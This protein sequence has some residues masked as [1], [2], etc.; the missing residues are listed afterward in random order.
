M[1]TKEMMMNSRSWMNPLKGSAGL[2]LVVFVLLSA[3]SKKSDDV[4]PAA[5]GVQ[6]KADAHF[7]NIIADDLGKTLYFFSTDNAGSN[8]C[9]GGCIANWPI[10]Y[11]SNPT[12]GSGLSQD[13]F[14]EITTAD[15]RKQT[16]YKGWPLYYFIDDKK[17]GDIFG[18]K[19]GN[20]WYV[21][22][23]DYEVM[24]SVNPANNKKYI[25]APKGK[26]LYI[27]DNDAN[28]TSSCTG[29]CT[30]NWP[31]FTINTG[32]VPSL[33]TAT[34]FSIVNG[35]Q[36]ATYKGKPLY[37][38]GQDAVRGDLRGDGAANGLWHMIDET[39]F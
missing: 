30:T 6:V 23:P 39:R 29:A 15:G 22:K 10:F 7:G 33:L 31:A 32:N 2:T 19:S 36:Q 26:T 12:L 18:D 9:T 25:V 21:A 38:F 16:T 8:T 20:L 13:D 37:Y 17:A 35:G 5:K 28:S 27:F 4:A 1:K 34:N 3:C 14:A 11:V 24:I